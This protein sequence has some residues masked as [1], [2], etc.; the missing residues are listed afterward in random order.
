M[1]AMWGVEGQVC[2]PNRKVS[3]LVGRDEHTS[4]LLS[5]TQEMRGQFVIFSYCAA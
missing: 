2:V 1:Q 3:R 5:V 4:E